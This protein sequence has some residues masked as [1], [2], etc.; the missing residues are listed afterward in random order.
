M[1]CAPSPSSPPAAGSKGIPRQEPRAA[2]GPSAAALG[3][4]RRPRRPSSVDRVVV[5]HRRRRR[6]PAPPASV[7]ADVVRPAARRSA[8]TQASSESALLHALD[9]L[10]MT[11]ATSPDVTVF[12]Q[13]TS[14]LTLGEPTWTPRWRASTTPPVDVAVAVAPFHGFLW[15]ADRRRHAERGRPRPART[16]R[17][18]R[19]ATPVLLETG[20]VYALRTAGSPCGAVTASSAASSA[21]RC[22]RRAASR[23]TSPPTSPG[24][25][26]SLQ[27]SGGPAP[28]RPFRARPGAVVFDFDGVFTDDR[29]LVDADGHETVACHRG[30]GL[31]LERLRATGVPLLVLTR[32]RVPIAAARARKLGLEALGGVDDKVT[33]LDRWLGERGLDWARVVYVGNDVNDLG[34]VV[35]AGCGVAVA[36]AEPALASAADLVLRRAGGAGAVRELCDL[37][38]DRLVVP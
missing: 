18:A 21:T 20:A 30:D 12:L 17:A 1:P 36:D 4:G 7:S 37:L 2:G 26:G 13:A 14:P 9:V 35:R 23:S 10:R 38:L 29:V 24:P 25:R 8:R 11:R 31:G 15:R 28:P 34:C 27:G 3:P 5:S 22:R 6:S 32:E 19:S 16:A 33:V